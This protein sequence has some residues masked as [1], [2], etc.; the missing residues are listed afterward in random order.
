[1]QAFLPLEEPVDVARDDAIELE[2]QTHDGRAWRWRGRIGSREFEQ[3]TRLAA[4]PCL[5][6]KK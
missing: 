1:M 2:L 4:P 6:A 3:S 5:A